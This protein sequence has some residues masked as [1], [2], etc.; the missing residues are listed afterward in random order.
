MLL[1]AA[2]GGELDGRTT[3]QKLIYF[4]ALKVLI[5]DANDFRPRYYG[6]FSRNTALSLERLV[7]LNFLKEQPRLT[8]SGYV[9]YLYKLNSDGRKVAEKLKEIYSNEYSKIR[10]IIKKGK[11]NRWLNPYV[12]SYAAKVYYILQQSKQPISESEAVEEGKNLRWEITKQ[13]AKKGIN[14]L[15]ALGLVERTKV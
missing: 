7:G 5:E 1:L 11:T 15:L 4:S 6:P 2:N 9:S 13:Q 3:V 8:Q 10:S 14:L 12:L